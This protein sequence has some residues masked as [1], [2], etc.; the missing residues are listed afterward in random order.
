MHG[1]APTEYL[2]LLSFTLGESLKKDKTI[3]SIDIGGTKTGLGV[4][5]P[6]A[7][8][9]AEAN[10]PTLPE[11]GCEALIK[12]V[13]ERS[14]E[15]LGQCGAGEIAGV[16]ML[17]PGP[18]DLTAGSIVHAPTMGW[19]DVP[20]VEITRN[21]FQ[22]PVVLQG[23]TAGAAFGEYMHGCGGET[24]VSGARPKSLFYITVSTG[25]G[26]G[27]VIDGKIYNGSYD[28]A[29]EL[30]HLRVEED[31]V[32]CPCGGR[33]CLE[34]VASGLGVARLALEMTGR[35]LDAKKVFESADAGD[36][37]CASIIAKAGRALGIGIS[38][39]I[40]LFDPQV[41]ILGSSVSNG[42]DRLKPHIDAILADRVQNFTKRKN[43]VRKTNLPLGHNALLGA[44]A[45]AEQS[46]INT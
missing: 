15:L 10:I 9:L 33:G 16:G 30:G 25:V 7:G 34:S 31:G 44:A 14:V 17:S 6:G 23:D 8:I 29:G 1:L 42:F 26:C 4:F 40:Q 45:L 3:I 13:Y 37:V 43:I 28:A 32:E 21:I 2:F 19:K 38:T 27:I 20:L 24:C 18:L 41:V 12:R 5:E 46:F 36:P 11:A 22:K 39:L 35:P